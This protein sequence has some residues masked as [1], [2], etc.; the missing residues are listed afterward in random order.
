MQ[1][2]DL[3]FAILYA[4]ICTTKG[5]SLEMWGEDRYTLI[6]V[7]HKNRQFEKKGKRTLKKR[8]KVLSSEF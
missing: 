1:D 5:A 2:E 6:S 8:L 4:L 3:T 7:I